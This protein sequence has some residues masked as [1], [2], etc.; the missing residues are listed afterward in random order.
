MYVP[1]RFGTFPPLAGAE[2]GHTH[3]DIQD[4]TVMECVGP[5]LCFSGT[6]YGDKDVGEAVRDLC[7]PVCGALLREVYEDV[8]KLVLLAAV[9]AKA[10]VIQNFYSRALHKQKV[11][12]T[13]CKR[14]SDD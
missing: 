4:G 3:F 1:V 5:H 13:S 2:R 10:S 14:R 12:L 8:A 9:G 7:G 11:S 6:K